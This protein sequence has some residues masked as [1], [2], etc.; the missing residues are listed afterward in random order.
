MLYLHEIKVHMYI[1]FLIDISLRCPHSIYRSNTQPSSNCSRTRTMSNLAV[2]ILHY[3]PTLVHWKKTLIT[4]PSTIQCVCCG[5]SLLKL[6][7]H[8]AYSVAN[9]SR[10]RAGN[11]TLVLLSFLKAL[12]ALMCCSARTF[13]YGKWARVFSAY[14]E[15]SWVLL[16]SSVKAAMWLL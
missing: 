2:A 16:I 3:I 8:K 4:K 12:R 5:G 14:S 11:S 13:R 1:M 10:C 9:N 6:S 7:S 15:D